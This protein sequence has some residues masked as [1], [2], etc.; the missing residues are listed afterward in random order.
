M[1]NLIHE[2]MQYVTIICGEA[3][4]LLTGTL[5]PESDKRRLE[6]IRR[7]AKHVADRLRQ[8]DASEDD[9]A[10]ALANKALDQLEV[11]TSRTVGHS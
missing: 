7:S 6:L 9:A 1:H 5:D 11:A 3:D 2:L 10:V 8:L 4:I